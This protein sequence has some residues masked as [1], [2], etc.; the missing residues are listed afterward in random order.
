MNIKQRLAKL[1]TSLRPAPKCEP[2]V[3][4]FLSD[5]QTVDEAMLKYMEL[6][7]CERPK[8]K[9][10]VFKGYKGTW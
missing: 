4:L 2:G 1:E 7:N 9:I 10:I 5:G 6:H 8:G 3:C